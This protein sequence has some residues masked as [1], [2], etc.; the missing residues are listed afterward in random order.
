MDSPT[1]SLQI[2]ET[3]AL[4]KGVPSKASLI[5]MLQ[6]NIYVIKFKKLNGETRE[7]TCTLMEEFLPTSKYKKTKNS[8]SVWDTDKNAWRSFRY[9]NL[10]SVTKNPDKIFSARINLL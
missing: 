6:N 8:I 2:D 1:K 9:T 5:D 10:I 3:V 7:M 4:I